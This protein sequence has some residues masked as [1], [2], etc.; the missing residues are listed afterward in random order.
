LY[1][2]YHNLGKNGVMDSLRDKFL[3]LPTEPKSKNNKK[4]E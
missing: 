1:D 3:A 2:S 4:G